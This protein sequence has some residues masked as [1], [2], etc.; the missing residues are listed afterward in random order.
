[1]IKTKEESIKE[2]AKEIRN[3]TVQSTAIVYYLL[4]DGT[5]VKHDYGGCH[6]MLHYP[7]VRSSSVIGGAAAFKGCDKTDPVVQDFFEWLISK[8]SVYYPVIKYLGKDFIPVRDDKGLLCGFIVTRKD[9]NMKLVFNLFK[10]LRTFGEHSYFFK[11]WEKWAIKE[12]SPRGL[13]YLMGY[14]YNINGEKKTPGHSPIE[15]YVGSKGFAINRFI[16]PNHKDWD[17]EWNQNRYD[18][19]GS[20]YAKENEFMWGVRSGKGF[21]PHNHVRKADASSAGVHTKYYRLY[22]LSTPKKLADADLRAFFKEA[23]EGLYGPTI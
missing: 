15:C 13:V 7:E 21:D 4:K 10:S 8:D 23:M 14:M 3:N 11:F 2:M 12:K 6:A 5:P 18:A 22:Y 20:S 16:N 1:M 9:L 19:S 17:A